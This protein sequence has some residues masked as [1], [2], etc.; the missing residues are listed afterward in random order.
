MYVYYYL[1]YVHIHA[2][3]VF[4]I[5]NVLLVWLNTSCIWYSTSMYI[6]VRYNA[7]TYPRHQVNSCSQQLGLCSL[8]KICKN[9]AKLGVHCLCQVTTEQKAFAAESLVL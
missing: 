9:H 5:M 6:I 1:L 7:C 2:F 8:C 3:N 4:D